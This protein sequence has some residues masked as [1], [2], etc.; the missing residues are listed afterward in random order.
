MTRTLALIAVVAVAAAAVLLGAPSAGMSAWMTEQAIS[1][2]VAVFWVLGWASVQIAV[3]TFGRGRF[4]WVGVIGLVVAVL[5]GSWFAAFGTRW[6][7]SE[8]P[9][10]PEMLRSVL[11]YLLLAAALACPAAAFIFRR[12][13][14]VSPSQRA[15]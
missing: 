4:P 3:R 15:D 14:N 5:S 11:D 1:R 13:V 6:D 2:L 8:V 9:Q 10:G 12:P 7:F